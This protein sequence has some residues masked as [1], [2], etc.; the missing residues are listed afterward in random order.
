MKSPNTVDNYRTQVDVHLLPALGRKRLGTL[1]VEHVERALREA[2]HQR[3]A[4]M[5]SRSSLVR[6]RSVLGMALDEAVR[7]GHLVRNVAKL[8][9]LPVRGR[10]PPPAVVHHRPGASGPRSA[11]DDRFEALWTVALL[12]GLRPGELLGLTWADVALDANPPVLHLRESM[13]FEYAIDEAGNRRPVY[14]LGQHKANARRRSVALPAPAVDALRRHRLRQLEERRALGDAWQDVF[15]DLG[16][17]VFPS[18]VGTPLDRANVRRAF[19]KLL[20]RAGVDGKWTPYEMRHTAV[21][22]L[23][24]AGVPPEQI[25]DLLGHVDTR[26]VLLT[27]RHA[28]VPVVDGA[29]AVMGSCSDKIEARCSPG[30]SHHARRRRKP[31]RRGALTC[32][33]GVELGGFEPPTSCMPCKRSSQLSYSPVRRATV[34]GAGRGA[35]PPSVRSGACTSRPAAG[36]TGAMAIETR[37]EPSRNRYELYEDGQLVSIAEYQV[38]GD[39]VVFFHTETI[40]S[41]QGNGLAE[42]LVRV[43]L[44][45]QRPTGRTVVPACWFVADFIEANPEY[46]PSTLTLE[47]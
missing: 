13:K 47:R 10:R 35:G 17:L 28:V 40:P 39:Q 6:L 41:R 16:G 45:D 42:E 7:R 12:R 1:T 19:A 34:A 27:Y 9:V 3:T 31:L 20:A 26:M 25:A 14:R 22:L 37:H 2:R 11:H 18:A 38:Q 4:E 5:L 15:G 46:R 8:A 30:C 24:D 23:S 44:D 21:S 29:S 36:T 33:Y 43:A 32:G